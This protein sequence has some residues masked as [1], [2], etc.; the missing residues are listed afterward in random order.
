MKLKCDEPLSNVAFNF[1]M[2]RYAMGMGGLPPALQS[3][4]LDVFFKAEVDFT[5]GELLAL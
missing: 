3:M 1:N 2:R 5:A 4:S